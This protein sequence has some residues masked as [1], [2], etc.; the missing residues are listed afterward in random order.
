MDFYF[1]FEQK[2]RGPRELIKNRQS[3]YLPF[4]QKCQEL[5]GDCEALDIGCGRGEWLELMQE[6]GIDATGVDLDDDMLSYC[7]GKG[8]RC[9]KQDALKALQEAAD[10]SLCIVSGFHIAEHLPFEIL[11]QIVHES[12]RVLKPAGLLI[13]ETPNP[14]NPTVG[15]C[16]FYNDPT[17]IRPIP[18]VLL[19]FIP[20]NEGFM[21]TKILRLQEDKN[22]HD[23]GKVSLFH[24]LAGASPDYSI[25]AQKEAAEE[26]TVLFDSL[27]QARYGLTLEELCVSYESKLLGIIDRQAQH[28]S[29]QEQHLS[30]LREQ[31]SA[32]KNHLSALNQQ[33]SEELGELRGLIMNTRHR[34][35]FGVFEW[36]LRKAKA[37]L[38]P[39]S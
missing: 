19:S 39:R 13:L 22:L 6:N 24:V 33:L 38:T 1:E 5:Y 31:I 18:P 34:T 8:F 21:R 15:S 4:V 16:H 14:E 12:K 26:L 35:L 2:Y 27:Y 17:H 29:A 11:R 32:Q 36:L 20:E 3:V 25:V 28:I 23:A 7:T 9:Q 30:D 37:R 10:E